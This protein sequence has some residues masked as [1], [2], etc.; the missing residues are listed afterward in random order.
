[1]SRTPLFIAV[2]VTAVLAGCTP[3]ATPTPT[4]STPPVTVAPTTPSASPTFQCTPEAGGAATPCSQSSYDA[5]KAK[6]ALYA[7]AE[8]VLQR[9]FVEDGKQ[10][11]LSG[12]PTISPEMRAVAS[13]GF[14]SGMT[15]IYESLA[16]KQLKGD[17]TPVVAYIRRAPGASK[18]G[19]TVALDACVDGSAVTVTRAGAPYGHG[20]VNKGTYFF[21][22]I[23]GTL[24]IV[25]TEGKQVASC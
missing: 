2:V 9:F 8:A 5:M 24:K 1:M 18:A 10:Q 12:H 14:L 25:T 19:S 6:D 7:E 20:Y 17:R 16:Q 4:T 3:T 22:P 15:T 13:G 21:A 11:Y 23:D